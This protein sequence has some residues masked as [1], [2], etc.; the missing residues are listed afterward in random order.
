M[1]AL[2]QY[3]SPFGSQFSVRAGS[4]QVLA[5]QIFFRDGLKMLLDQ[6]F[7]TRSKKIKTQ[8]EYAETVY[9]AQCDNTITLEMIKEYHFDTDIGG[10]VC[11]ATAENSSEIDDLIKVVLQ[12]TSAKRN[13]DTTAEETVQRLVSLLKQAKN[14]ETNEIVSNINDIHHIL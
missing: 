12:L 5:Y 14:G 6:G 2:F 10:F 13:S 7:N 8:F 1:I 9:Q 3:K 11:L 4:A